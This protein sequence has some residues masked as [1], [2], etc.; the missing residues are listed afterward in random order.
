MTE[1]R[2]VL[3][4]LGTEELP[5]LALRGLGEALLAGFRDGLGQETIPFDSAGFFATPRRLAVLIKGCAV[6][7][8]D[9]ESERLG[10][11]VAAAFD[12]SGAPSRA[13][14]GFA[15]SCGV[16]PEALIRVADDKGERLAYRWRE[17]GQASRDLLPRIAEQAVRQLPIPKRMRWGRSRVQFVR[18]VHWLVFLMGDDIVPCE[19]LGLQSGR[20]SQGHRFHAAGPLL[21]ESPSR[22]SSQLREQG[23]VIADFAE[24]RECIREQVDRLAVE[25]GG[26]A[27]PDDALLDEV[28]ALTEWPVAIRGSFEAAFLEV[29][30]ELLVLTMKQDQRYFPVFDAEGVLMNQFITVANIDSS[31]PELVRHG[32]E[33]VIRPRFADAKF[34][35]DQDLKR[36]LEDRLEDLKQV[37]FQ[38]QLGSMHDKSARVAAL[39]ADI[40]LLVGADT[41]QARRAGWLSR[42]DLVTETVF[43]FPGM[44]GIAGRYLLEREGADPDTARALE[45]F[46]MPRHAGETLPE[47]RLG[48]VLSLAEKL[49]TLVG[50]FAI[51]ESPSGDKDPYALRRAALGALRMLREKQL[52]MPLW[53]V[54]EI[55]NQRQPEALRRDET[56]DAVHAFMMERLKGIY[57]EEGI[58]ASVFASVLEVAPS[59]IA[60]FDR[61]I[62]AVSA[63]RRRPEAGALAEANKRARNILRKA[64]F[65]AQDAE[66]DGGLL[67]DQAEVRLNEQA[68]TLEQQIEPLLEAGD[69][70][71]ALQLLAGLR[72]PLDRFFNEV[73]VMSDDLARRANRLALLSRLSGLFLRVA[74]VAQL[75]ISTRQGGHQAS[76]PGSGPS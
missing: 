27:R 73:M 11:T 68:A 3:F 69:Y 32:N 40:A 39:A 63:F 43:E 24:R 1:P 36:R 34:F 25:A 51:G 38:E 70:D 64:D 58:D 59:T 57:L 30:V 18:P 60:E 41:D 52:R 74:D 67:S 15:R 8:P 46:Y 44:Q 72:D 75:Q 23:W 31:D 19:L 20:R 71:A 2:D 62:A 13:A 61:R 17:P 9:R 29:P 37:V 12:E 65:H 42:C 22:Y 56:V 53:A 28:A 33:R 55:A 49:D 48:T 6:R 16:A 21:L 76:T 45:E 7:Q 66:V 10:P 14:E 50:I 47:T 54:L 26:V 35:W 4:E 5:P